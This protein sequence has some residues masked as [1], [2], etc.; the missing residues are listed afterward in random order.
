M[1]ITPSLI[2]RTPNRLR[3]LLT[4]TA[5]SP[6]AQQN[7]VLANAGGAT[8]DLLTD[9]TLGMG[10]AV[11]AAAGQTPSPA[12]APSRGPLLAIIRARLDGYG[13]LAAGALNQTQARALLD[14]WEA[15]VPPVVISS[16]MVGRAQMSIRVVSGATA[17]LS[18]GVDANVDGDGDPI[19]DIEAFL[20]QQA[21]TVLAILSIEFIVSNDR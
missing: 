6:A 9:A 10:S 20:T 13:P 14:S 4:I 16:E 18:I 8:P 7:L 21:G 11:I 17:G 2:D 1:A 3:Y 12:G 19:V 5:V 15:A